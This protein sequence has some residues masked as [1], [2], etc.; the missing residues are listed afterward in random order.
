MVILIPKIPILGIL[1]GL[2]MEYIGIFYG[3]FV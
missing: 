3:L 2:G 1:E